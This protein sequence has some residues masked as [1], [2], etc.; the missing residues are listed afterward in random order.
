MP[1]DSTGITGVAPAGI[2]ADGKTILFGYAHTL[3]DL[4]VAEGLR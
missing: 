1:A 3:P 2:S 4:Y